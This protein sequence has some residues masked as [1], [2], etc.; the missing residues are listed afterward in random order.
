MLRLQL[1]PFEVEKIEAKQHNS[2][3]LLISLASR[4]EVDLQLDSK[5]LPSNSKIGFGIDAFACHVVVAVLNRDVENR[6]HL[7][8]TWMLM[9]SLN[10]MEYLGLEDISHQAQAVGA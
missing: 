2:W 8:M 10:L 4:S 9:G 6:I 1:D 5:S 7:K 3:A